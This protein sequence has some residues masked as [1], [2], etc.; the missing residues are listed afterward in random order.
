VNKYQNILKTSSVCL[1]HEAMQNYIAGKL[2]DAQKR[3]VEVHL[4]DC[5][6]C[7]DELDGLSQIENAEKLISLVSILNAQIDKKVLESKQKKITIFKKIKPLYSIAALLLVLVGITVFFVL[8]NDVS[9][10]ELALSQP[11]YAEKSAEE[12]SDGETITSN[13]LFESSKKDQM[14]KGTIFT[15]KQ[16]QLPEISSQ[17]NLL[18]DESIINSTIDTTNL[19]ASNIINYESEKKSA[20][21]EVT[22]FED[23][24][25]DNVKEE[26]IVDDLVESEVLVSDV[27]SEKSKRTVDKNIEVSLKEAINQYDNK[28]YNKALEILDQLKFETQNKEYFKT[29]WYKSLV[30][31][32][33]NQLPKAKIILQ[34]LAEKKNDYQLKAKQKLKKME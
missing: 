18:S 4:A 13:N 17:D 27:V 32:E 26:K 34:S 6:M 16:I 25:E 31:I 33:L 23:L 14:T 8:K 3:E 9:N 11:D 10:S 1:S 5:E 12:I 30:Y 19:I 2:S 29:L 28:N 20:G 24:E 7:F 15:K 22:V 21:V